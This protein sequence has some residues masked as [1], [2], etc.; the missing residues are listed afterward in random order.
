MF[1][2]T[3]CLFRRKII[4]LYR[5]LIHTMKL[6]REDLLFPMGKLPFTFNLHVL[7]ILWWTKKDFIWNSV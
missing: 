1:L 4:S 2:L 7:K 5:T 3:V 6:C